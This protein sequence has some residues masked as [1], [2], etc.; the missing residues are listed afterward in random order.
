MFGIFTGI[1]KLDELT[2]EALNAFNYST[3]FIIGKMKDDQVSDYVFE[4]IFHLLN[5][6][7]EVKN[8]EVMAKVISCLQDLCEGTFSSLQRYHKMMFQA[9]FDCNSYSTQS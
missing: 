4:T 9:V 2:L 8:T 6:S 7:R 5:Q 3:D 1:R